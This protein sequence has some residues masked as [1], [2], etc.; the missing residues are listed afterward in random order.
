MRPLPRVAVGAISAS[1]ASNLSEAEPMCWALLA[2]LQSVG[3][4][5]AQFHSASYL[6]PH[7]AARSL[8]TCGSRHLDSWAMSRTACLRALGRTC[9]HA[10]LAIVEGAWNSTEEASR[11][12][13][14]SRLETLCDWLQ[15]PRIGIVDLQSLA[16][17]RLPQRPERLDALLLD[18]ADD[19][20]HAAHWQTNFEAIWGVPVLGWLDR[21]DSLRTL[22]RTLP[23]GR[24]PSPALCQALGRRLASNLRLD[25]LLALAE[26]APLPA[27]PADD[28]LFELPDGPMRIAVAYDEDFCGY[29]PDTL[30]LLEL[31]GAEL[32][33]F[34][35][36][37]DG[38]LP[39]G[40]DVVYIGSGH[41]ERQPEVLAGN[42]CLL[43]SL[44]DFA[45]R[46]GR[47]YAEGT[48]VAYLSRELV[49]AGD[50]KQTE[51]RVPMTGLLPAVAHWSP[52]A[53]QPTPAEICFARDSWMIEAGISIRGYRQTTWN[54][55]PVG[56]VID[57]ADDPRHTGE[58]LGAENVVGSQITLN[59]AANE[60]LLRRFV[61]PAMAAVPIRRRR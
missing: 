33:D 27:L 47:I 8:T 58:V 6:M 7:D 39:D 28:E 57:Y 26:R 44:R 25:K 14:S 10:D 59:L 1:D 20:R 31:A 50:C 45:A 61:E 13:T 15:L 22:C 35:P 29:F 2:A 46:G 12:E 18:R 9:E 3:R 52:V 43:Q 49:F 53:T 60:H 55:E 34:S 24:D 40:T 48:G 37:R 17:C 19:P 38:Q 30:D 16:D 5:V 23:A 51:R 54:I 4:E 42:H 32:C 21:A 36:L 41:P 56:P 11:L